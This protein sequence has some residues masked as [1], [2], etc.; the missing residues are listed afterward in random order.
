MSFWSFFELTGGLVASVKGERA[1]R[2]VAVVNFMMDGL[3]YPSTV[4]VKSKELS[5]FISGKCPE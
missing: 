5:S 1:K 4:G 3:T 2:A